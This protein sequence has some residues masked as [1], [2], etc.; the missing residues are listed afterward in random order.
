M[1][2]Y[3]YLFVKALPYALALLI[4]V[5]FWIAVAIVRRSDRKRRGGP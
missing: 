3:V 1:S 4:L 2:A 5:A